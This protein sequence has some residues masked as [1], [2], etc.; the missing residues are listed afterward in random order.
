MDGTIE[1]EAPIEKLYI[2]KVK[3][4]NLFFFFTDIAIYAIL[5]HSYTN[6]PIIFRIA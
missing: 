1:D 3:I 2:L 6:Y 4:C 5:I